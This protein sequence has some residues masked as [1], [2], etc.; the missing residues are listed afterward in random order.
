MERQKINRGRSRST[1]HAELD[2]F[3]F[4]CFVEG[5]KEMYKDL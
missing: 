4:S 1:D 2:H 3:T 5:G